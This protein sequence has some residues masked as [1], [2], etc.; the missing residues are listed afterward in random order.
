MRETVEF[1]YL[2]IYYCTQGTK[3]NNNAE[4][5]RYKMMKTQG[6]PNLGLGLVRFNVPLDT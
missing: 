3:I 6:K 1:I 2:F 5:Q 4:I